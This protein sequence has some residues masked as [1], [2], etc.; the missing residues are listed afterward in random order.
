MNEKYQK[1][2]NFSKMNINKKNKQQTFENDELD[3]LYN[4][5]D[6]FLFFDEKL[7]CCYACQVHTHNLWDPFL[8][9]IFYLKAS[10]S[11]VQLQ[12]FNAQKTLPFKIFFVASQG[13]MILPAD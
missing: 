1:M 13:E 6:F 3:D 10:D 8:A 11:I 12:E 7:P 2:S 5:L 9:L 4:E